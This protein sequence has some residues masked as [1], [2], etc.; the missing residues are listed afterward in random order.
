MCL[1]VGFISLCTDKSRTGVYH[2]KVNLRIKSNSSWAR[3]LQFS[4]SIRTQLSAVVFVFVFLLLVIRSEE[5]HI[6]TLCFRTRV[7]L[8]NVSALILY[9]FSTVLY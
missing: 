3:A 6:S 8:L 7:A 9:F 5:T 2:F 1:N 4:L